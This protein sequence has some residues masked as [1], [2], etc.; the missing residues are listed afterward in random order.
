GIGRVEHVRV[1]RPRGH[2]GRGHLPIRRDHPV[3]RT[4]RADPER[5]DLARAGRL[6]LGHKPIA[7]GPERGLATLVVE[8]EQQL[9]AALAERGAA[10]VRAMPRGTQMAWPMIVRTAVMD[11]IILRCV[12]DGAKTVLNL[13]AGLDTRPFRLAL[14]SDLRWFHVDLP[15]MVAYLKEQMAGE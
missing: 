4:F 11:E 7:G 1:D 14:P 12:N 10:I 15:D 6:E 13:A 2:E 3:G 9:G 5:Q 8:L